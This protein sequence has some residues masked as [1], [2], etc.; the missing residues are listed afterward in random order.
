MFMKPFKYKIFVQLSIII[1]NRR[2]KKN[3]KPLIIFFVQV[4]KSA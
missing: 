1:G 4:K 3:E 2:V